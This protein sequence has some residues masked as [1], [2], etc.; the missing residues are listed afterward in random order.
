MSQ[1]KNAIT[2][3]ILLVGGSLLFS[4]LYQQE[5]AKEL[6]EK[7]MYLEETKGDLEKA[8]AVYDRIV[9]EFPDGRVIAAK[10]QLQIGMCF[11]KLGIE[12]AQKAYQNVIDKYPEQTEAVNIAKEKLS[13]L[14]KAQAIVAKSDVDQKVTKIYESTEKAFGFISPDGKKLALVGG[15]GDIWIREIATGKEMRL[16]QTPN[17]KYWCFWSPDSKTIAF[18][19]VLNGLFV[20]SVRGG[21]PRALIES[22]SDFIKEGNY[23]WP[24]GWT[25]DSQM[26]LCQVSK[27][28]L[29]AIPISGE[30]WKDIF[31][32][33]DQKTEKDYTLMT[34][35][36]NGK[37]LAYESEKDIYI[38][39][40]DGGDS[41]QIT[42]HPA[43]DS[44]PTWSFDG[45]WISFYSSRSGDAEIWVIKISPDGYPEGDPIQV[46]RGL[47]T[48]N[49]F[50]SWAKDGKIGI[51]L[52]TSV[53]NI[54]VSDLETGE[55]TQLTNI[56]TLDRNPRW[57]PNGVQVA[58]I[59]YRE[60]KSDLWTISSQG[61]E[62]KKLTINVPNPKENRYITRPSWLTDGKTLIF[63]GFFGYGNRG[64]WM[65][66]VE[67]G[68]PQKMKFDF[69]PWV[70]CCDV[71]PDGAYIAFDYIGADEG[72][73]IEGS[74]TFEKDIYVIPFKG[75]NPQRITKI[76]KSGLSFHSPRWS[77]DG[78]KIAF[79]SMNWF[80]D[81]EG[82]E[83]EEIWVYEFPGGELKPI[84]K[85]MKGYPTHLSWS[86]DGK[87]IVFSLLEKNKNQIYAVPSGGGEI[88]KL[89][90][91]GGNPDFS[92]DGKK[93]VYGKR[94]LSRVEYWLV[95]NFL[96]V[97]KKN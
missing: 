65:V 34:L 63:G 97:E 36:P 56:L 23:A 41:T 2:V 31:K 45:K 77:P 46:F 16:T 53:S 20:V 73:P 84:T 71:S 80:E 37:F 89:N 25:S 57:S 68:M 72:N 22:D 88:K 4:N 61:E 35:S 76:E 70:D 67:G 60:G 51:S 32:Y 64:I 19:D 59:S 66:P 28:G 21:E 14:I 75:G 82:K 74:R 38:M 69:D 52:N 18:L 92:P 79:R 55:E 83:S 78:K 47:T 81:N 15:E 91:E 62:A 40:A 95:E 50:Y 13:L 8:I 30:E 87:T 94:H 39:P 49:T 90:I 6:F 10:A 11:E 12:E 54:F 3:I 29:C 44:W 27:K 26:I 85:K 42:K 86:P 43:S 24:T 17:F 1:K 93:I 7:A 5:T 58:F 48:R 33:P 96:P 9:K